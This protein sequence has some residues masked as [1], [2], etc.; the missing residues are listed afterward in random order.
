MTGRARHVVFFAVFALVSLGALV[1]AARLFPQAIPIVNLDVSMSRDDALARARQV[2]ADRG[3]APGEAQAA[4]RFGHDGNAQNYVELEGGG[5]AAFAALTRGGRY[6]PYW[7]EVRLFTPGVIDEVTLRFRPD[8]T[9]AGFARRVADAYVR[10]AATKALPRDAARALA[11]ARARDDWAIDLSQYALVEQSQQTRPNGRVDHLFVYERP[12]KLGEATLRLRLGVAG[13]ELI[14]ALPFVRIPERFERRFTE[15]RSDNRVIGTVAGIAALLLYGV[16]GVVLGSLW[17]SR[18]HWLEWRPP[19]VA[20]AVV[21][22]LMAAAALANAP[23]G[24]FGADT[25][26]TVATFWVKQGGVAA[27]LLVFGALGYGAIFMA[28]ESLA[29]RAFPRQPQLWRVWSAAAA[30]TPQ[31][32]GRTLGGY[33]FVPIEL[34]FIATFYYA[35]NRWLGW[36]QPSEVLTDPNILGSA[37]PA[38]TPIATSLQAGFME[39]CAFRAIPLALGALVGARY[40]RRTL[41]I[42][43]AVV[44]QALVFGGAH[45]TYPGFP[46]YSRPLELFLPSIVWALIFLRYGLLP[47][48]L[49]HAL[50]DLVLFAIPVFLVD[51][52]GARVQQGLIVAAALVPLAIVAWRIARAGGL[53]TFP[54]SCWNAAWQPRVPVEE[55]PRGADAHADNRY[56]AAFQ[57]A[58]PLLGVA[59]LAAWLALGTFRADVPSPRGDRPAAIGAAEAALAARGVRLGPDWVRTAVVRGAA[60]DAQSSMHKFVWQE[61]GPAA[62]RRL[63]GPVLPPPTWDVRFATFTGDLDARAEDWRVSVGPDG[64]VRTIRHTLPESRA[65]ATLTR[66]AAQARAEAEL[67]SRYG[68]D[69][70]TLRLVSANEEKLPARTD[71][72]FTWSDPRVDV[73][74]GGE[75]RTVVAL[76]GDE[77]VANGRYVFVPEEWTRNEQVQANRAQIAA[78]AGALVFVVAGLAGLVTGIVAWTR[79]RCDVR[80][81]VLVFATSALVTLA[82]AANNVPAFAMSLRT[83][84]PLW[85]QWLTRVLGAV[86]AGLVGALLFGLLAGVGAWG[87]RAAPRGRVAGRLPPWLAA[88]AAGLLVTGL[89]TALGSLAPRTVPPWPPLPQSQWS[90]MVGAALGAMNFVA[91]AGVGLFVVYLVARLT[92]GFSRRAWIGVGI[93]VLLQC[94]AALAQAGGQYAGALA[95]GVAGGLT[96]GAVLW[97]LLRYDV[98]MVPP[99]LA[100]GAILAGA[101]RAAQAGTSEGWAAFA[102]NAL[103]TVAM[104]W[105]VVRYIDRPLPV[106]AQAAVRPAT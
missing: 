85:S 19:L 32:L 68:A 28:A 98:R 93:V 97:W 84:E 70:A 14:G 82:Q 25:T 102:V 74:K 1:V 24:W 38:L 54:A 87:A 44:V 37:I 88:V 48:V 30:P 56:A 75:A 51:A 64:A 2:A 12:E 53:V 106:A 103:V 16:G 79:H 65:G 49:L 101:A 42:A 61:A 40:G 13:D 46:A 62:Y 63:V 6:T 91:L 47:T 72:T 99:Y 4:A 52:P 78:L 3:L 96:A 33:L 18:R 31:V 86:A 34:A 57:R 69:P 21:S 80:A 7:W 22:T 73:G 94:A 100:T 23:S 5:K 50:F 104:A 83:A 90:V 15:L 39:E 27:F 11:E 71:W 60:V 59:G 105:L 76:S 81:L 36:W 10:D 45:A 43:I 26:E 35:T 8:G 66:E 20:G 77:P 9:P 55:A 58:L 92:H 17:L 95:A 67:R 41:G 29:R 89:Q